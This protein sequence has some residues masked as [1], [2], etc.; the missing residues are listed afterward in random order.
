[1]MT[2]GQPASCNPFVDRLREGLPYTILSSKRLWQASSLPQHID[3]SNG[4]P[5]LL[6]RSFLAE[7]PNI[8]PLAEAP[9]P[10]VAR[11]WKTMIIPLWPRYPAL[12][13]AVCATGANLSLSKNHD[14]ERT[15]LQ[16]HRKSLHALGVSLSRNVSHHGRRTFLTE[17]MAASLVLCLHN[18]S[19]ARSDGDFTDVLSHLRCFVEILRLLEPDLMRTGIL[20]FLSQ[21]WV[22]LHEL[23][24]S[25]F[26]I[27]SPNDYSSSS[28]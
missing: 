8:L 17:L 26:D 10:I 28:G 4:S 13:Y 24:S 2:N 21:I 27:V 22:S 3:F 5:E 16:H 6:I 12:F 15:A 18:L 11:Q 7:V 1:M 23:I 14:L 19:R 25:E 20:D 9:T